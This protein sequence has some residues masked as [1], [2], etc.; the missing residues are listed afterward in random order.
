MHPK[1]PFRRIDILPSSRPVRITID[2]HAVASAAH[3]THLLET[4]LPTRYYLPPTSVDPALLRPS[5]TRTQC[6]YKGEAEYYGVEL[7]G[8]LH[9]DVVWFYRT[10][11]RESAMVAGLLCFYNE[12]VDV[13]L[14]GEKLERP[15]T[16]FG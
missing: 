5:K 8:T 16:P 1:D 14:D 3:S 15:K 13:W 10:P 7:A 9:E 4:G 12:R 2:G 6:P 11:T